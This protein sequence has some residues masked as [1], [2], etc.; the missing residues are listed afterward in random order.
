MQ[1]SAPISRI[2]IPRAWIGICLFSGNTGGIQCGTVGP[3][4]SQCREGQRRMT[5]ESVDIAEQ[6]PGVGGPPGVAGEAGDRR[7]PGWT[8]GVCSLRTDTPR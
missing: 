1:V 8:A 4:Q 2:L 7:A 5:S 6:L 3:G